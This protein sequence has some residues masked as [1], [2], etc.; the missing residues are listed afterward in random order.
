MRMPGWIDRDD[1]EPVSFHG[2]VELAD[3]RSFPVLITNISDPGCS[4]EC[5]ATL[6]IAQRVRLHVG[7]KSI[8]AEVRWALPGSAGLRLIDTGE[9]DEA[10]PC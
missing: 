9:P 3:G 2:S 1:R 8:G 10:L 5:E 4:I 6:P 7:E